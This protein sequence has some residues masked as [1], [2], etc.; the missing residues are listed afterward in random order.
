MGTQANSPA[1]ARVALEAK[2]LVADARGAVYVD[3][4][5]NDNAA[6]LPKRWRVPSSNL[7]A[8]SI[9][10][11]NGNLLIDG[12]ASRAGL[13]ALM[14]PARLEDLA[15]YRVDVEFSIDGTADNDLSRWVSVMY[16][17]SPQ[18]GAMASDTYH[19]FA[20]RRDATAGNGT[21]FAMRKDGAWT[22]QSIQPFSQ[23]IDQS[24]TY[25]STVI[26]YG[27]RVRQYLNDVLLHD[28]LIPNGMDKGGI[29]LQT[30]GALYRIKNVKV[31]EQL[32]PLPELDL[33]V[34]VQDT[35]TAASMAPTLVQGMKTLASTSSDGSSNSLYR[36]DDALVLWS[37]EGQRLGSL[38]ELFAQPSR[39]TVPVLRIS[40]RAT[41]DA[42]AAFSDRTHV[43][44][45]ITL[46]SDN[47]DLLLYAR[48]QLPA[49]RTAV[50]FSASAFTDRNAALLKISGDTNRARAKIA[51]LPDT[52]L[53]RDLVAHL[54]RL[55]LTVWVQSGAQSAE[56]AAQVLTTGVN[57]VVAN[58]SA[59]FAQVLRKLPA[60]TLLRKPLV[61]GHRGMPAGA[62]NDENTLESAFAALSAGADAVENDIFIT[63]DGHLVIMHDDTVDRT[64]NGKGAIESMTLAQVKALRTKGHSMQVPTMREYFRAFKNKPITHFIEL[65][66]RTP[67]VVAQ[68]KKEIAEEGVADQ[69]IAISFIPE[70]LQLSTSTNPEL[71]LGYLGA[72]A[73][74]D[75]LL[76]NVRSVLSTNQTRNSTF[77]PNYGVISRETME[78][79]KHR[80]ATFWPWTI[81]KADDFYKFYSWGTS[82]IT[83]DYARLAS[84]F[85]VEIAPATVPAKVELNAAT[86]LNVTLTTQTG[87]VS[88]VAANE[89]VVLDGSAQ[90]QAPRNGAVTF[91]SAGTAVV[92]PGYRYQMGSSPY[93]YVIFSKPVTLVVGNA[94]T[95]VN[96]K[97]NAKASSVRVGALDGAASCS[98]RESGQDNVCL[99]TLV[100]N[101]VA[102]VSTVP[103]NP[104]APALASKAALAAPANPAAV[105]TLSMGSVVGLSWGLGALAAWRSRRRGLRL[106]S[107]PSPP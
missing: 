54:Q 77:N 82:G 87:V 44:M 104:A 28:V 40:N 64:T 92:L 4:W 5:F 84:N 15:N 47:V 30:S 31:T 8:V 83:T 52:L 32:T 60:N 89:L 88:T 46:L 17:T 25:R 66:S 91:T 41:V 11:G 98:G 53:Q 27:N 7:G 101:Q 16:R 93:S 90:A 102:K 59:V 56:Q 1:D 50:D 106:S 23:S 81:D 74:S 22:V 72:A 103:E 33:P 45:D 105:P 51:I 10:P 107:L 62:E 9:D 55:L 85:P 94:K 61:V 20:I 39:V 63:S 95:N 26:V 19:Q 29:G 67:A 43:L 34:A 36:L 71:A 2:L 65:K 78:A 49:V 75:N 96:P 38:K 14:L 3:K 57:G 13:T 70:Q 73:N 6:G 80:G 97:A 86:T 99:A 48:T 37:A 58:D 76:F 21:E 12:R 35:G 24:Q 100:E 42:L 69:S 18:A 68:L 79:T